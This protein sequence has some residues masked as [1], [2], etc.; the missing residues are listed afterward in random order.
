MKIRPVDAELFHAEGQADMTN[1][2]GA[3]H[4]FAIMP[5]NLNHAASQRTNKVKSC[6]ISG[7]HRGA[8]NILTLLGFYA[9]YVGN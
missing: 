5:K 6:D 4:N 1:L 7:F 3:F 2:I 8:V 9:A